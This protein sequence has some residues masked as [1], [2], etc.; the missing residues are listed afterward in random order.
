MENVW[1]NLRTFCVGNTLYHRVY[2]GKN[3]FHTYQ[4]TQKPKSF[5]NKRLIYDPNNF[6]KLYPIP[7]VVLD[8]RPLDEYF[9][10][11][12]TGMTHRGSQ[13]SLKF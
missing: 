10:R 3:V 13:V 5:L 2:P 1:P 11:R 12:D 9:S 6:I 8:G 4:V 7:Q